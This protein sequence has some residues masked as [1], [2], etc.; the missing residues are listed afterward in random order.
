MLDQTPFCKHFSFIPVPFKAV[1]QILT[2]LLT[3][4]YLFTFILVQ[5]ATLNK[6]RFFMITLFFLFFTLM[7]CFIGHHVANCHYS[8]LVGFNSD[9]ISLG[10]FV[11]VVEVWVERTA[12]EI[13]VNA[14]CD[15]DLV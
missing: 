6:L 4:K 11:I 1:V 9:E 12:T 8:R 3:L 15:H 13:R 7:L 14:F 10:A 2:I 5:F